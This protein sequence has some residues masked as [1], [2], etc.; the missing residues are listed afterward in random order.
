MLQYNVHREAPLHAHARTHIFMHA[1]LAH[2]AIHGLMP[3]MDLSSQLAFAVSSASRLMS[4]HHLP[5]YF[6]YSVLPEPAMDVLSLPLNHRQQRHRLATTI[7]SVDASSTPGRKF[8][9]SCWPLQRNSIWPSNCSPNPRQ[10]QTLDNTILEG[11]HSHVWLS[12]SPCMC[13]HNNCPRATCSASA[14]HLRDR[15]KIPSS[16]W[17]HIQQ[18]LP[19]HQQPRSLA[20]TLQAA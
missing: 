12:T 18:P 17:R 1:M 15:R 3:Y 16:S 10:W 14:S 5:V 4:R 2:L 7:I 20:L 11:M 19:S 6:T 9:I 8:S 13:L